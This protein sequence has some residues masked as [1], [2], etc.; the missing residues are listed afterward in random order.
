MEGCCI[1]CT[2]LYTVNSKLYETYLKSSLY[3]CLDNVSY[4]FSLKNTNIFFNHNEINTIL[5]NL[6]P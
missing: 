5:T 4:S 6:W 1:K 3:F 2:S